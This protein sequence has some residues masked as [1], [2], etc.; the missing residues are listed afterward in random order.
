MKG[1]RQ[2]GKRFFVYNNDEEDREVTHLCLDGGKLCVPFNSVPYFHRKLGADIAKG[3]KNY[4]VERR[5]DVFKFHADLDLFEPTIKDYKEIVDWITNDMNHVLREF[6]PQFSNSDFKELTVFICTTDPKRGIEKYGKT[7]DKVGIHLLYPWL[8]ADTESSMILRSAFIQYF[9]NKYG[10]R[11]ENYNEWADV[12]DKTVYVSNGLRMVGC[13]KME[14]CKACKGQYNNSGVCPD[15]LCEGKGKYDIG[16]IYKIHE[17]IRGNGSNN[18]KL[19]NEVLEDE[20]YMTNVCSI[21]CNP[22][23]IPNEMIPMQHYPEWFDQTQEHEPKRGGTS[24]SNSSS[25]SGKSKK[26]VKVKEH[27]FKSFSV[28]L[29]G[30][31]VRLADSDKRVKKIKQWF[32]NDKLHDLFKI[33]DVYRNSCINDVI[34]CTPTFEDRYYLINVDSQYCLNLGTCHRSNGIYFIINEEGLFQKC[35][36]RCNT[37]DGRLSGVKCEHFTS[38]AFYLPDDLEP[39]LFSSFDDKLHSK[40]SKFVD[41]CDTSLSNIR[42][43][44]E[45]DIAFLDRFLG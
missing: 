2:W 24:N 40:F 42:T 6:Y 11:P 43:K 9:T 34:M 27:D 10:E 20:I 8:L 41:R 12:F 30:S 25:S 26:V 13:G 7:Y 38:D 35:F 22:L 39:I 1:V 44:K 29:Q 14:R 5:T 4:I 33:P 15:G 19:L 17:I 16:R 45:L 32:K 21:R 31:K 3:V 18:E 37:L 28:C 23:E 36:C